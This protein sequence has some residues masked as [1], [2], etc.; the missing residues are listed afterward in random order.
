MDDLE[1]IKAK[2]AG[3]PISKL[4]ALAISTGVPFGTLFKVKYGTTKNPRYDTVKPVADYMRAHPDIYGA[5]EARP[6]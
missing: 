4:P 2:L 3:V 6:Q 5:P 1:F